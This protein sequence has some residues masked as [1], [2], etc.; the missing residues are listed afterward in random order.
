MCGQE[1]TKLGAFERK[2]N[3]EDVL[4]FR[5]RKADL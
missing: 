3:V 2:M 4:L 5:Y 1:Y